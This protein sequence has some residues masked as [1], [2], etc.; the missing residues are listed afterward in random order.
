MRLLRRHP[1]K[2]RL[3]VERPTAVFAAA[4][5]APLGA[6]APPT[7]EATVAPAVERAREWGSRSPPPH[8][9][10]SP[11]RL[12]PIAAS[13]ASATTTVTS[14]ALPPDAAVCTRATATDVPAPLARTAAAAP[15]CRAG[16]RRGGPFLQP[17]AVT[18]PSPPPPSAATPPENTRAFSAI[19]AWSPRRVPAAVRR[20]LP[21]VAGDTP[22]RGVH[23]RPAARIDRSR[24]PL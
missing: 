16:G 24:P 23:C 19:S 3:V 21:R 18:S 22:R 9:P 17:P 8:S 5:P 11:Q 4:Q 12:P 20:R 15:R 2:H 1:R 10:P 7:N 6:R 14:A 13:P